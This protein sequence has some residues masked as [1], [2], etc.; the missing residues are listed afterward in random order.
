[1][2]LFCGNIESVHICPNVLSIN[3][4]TGITK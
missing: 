1:V 4:N 3:I 2:Q